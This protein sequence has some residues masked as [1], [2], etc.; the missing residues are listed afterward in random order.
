MT[1]GPEHTAEC[2]AKSEKY[3]TC[4]ALNKYR[5]KLPIIESPIAT[6]RDQFA[7]AA[8]T[9]LMTSQD[10]QGEW[11]HDVLGATRI[12]YEVADAMLKAREE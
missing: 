7:M 4:G 1:F 5:P 2:L 10:Q 8:L 6:L 12:A 9:G 11:Q 3:C